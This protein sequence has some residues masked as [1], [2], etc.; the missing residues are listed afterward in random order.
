MHKEQ[1]LL[2]LPE[3][4]CKCSHFEHIHNMTFQSIHS[5][6]NSTERRRVEIP[7]V[8]LSRTINLRLLSL[9]LDLNS[10]KKV[11]ASGHGSYGGPSAFILA[12]VT[13]K[14]GWNRRS[15]SACCSAQCSLLLGKCLRK[16]WAPVE[17]LGVGL[18]SWPASRQR[19]NTDNVSSSDSS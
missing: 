9:G 13:L 10:E 1:N 6:L 5:E 2:T 17:W 3:Y 15:G 18:G 12:M 4:L 11:H 7:G 19:G 14:Q 8:S 16:L